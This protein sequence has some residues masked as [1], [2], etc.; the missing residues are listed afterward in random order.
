MRLRPPRQPR[1][2]AGMRH[3]CKGGRV[4][5]RARPA[6]AALSALSLLLC[7]A[8]CVL[9]VDSYFH[10]EGLE[11]IPLRPDG[12]RVMDQVKWTSRRGRLEFHRWRET[13]RG[14][15]DPAQLG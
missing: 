3:A 1:T 6:C 12:S 15:F 10:T 8:I 5:R 2:L 4:K 7:V 11:R 9:W 14:P 13:V